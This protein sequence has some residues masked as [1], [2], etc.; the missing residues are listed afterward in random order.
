MAATALLSDV[1]SDLV[2]FEGGI[3]W[4]I[5]AQH[6]SHRCRHV[7]V[8]RCRHVFHVSVTFGLRKIFEEGPP[9]IAKKDVSGLLC[10]LFWKF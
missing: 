9:V 1:F 6:G 7:Q 3:Q 4:Q 2:L 8:E 10:A 5:F